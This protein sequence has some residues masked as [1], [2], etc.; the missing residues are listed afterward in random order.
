[1]YFCLSDA[2]KCKKLTSLI[3]SLYY[4]E[5]AVFFRQNIGKIVYIEKYLLKNKTS[6]AHFNALGM[7]TICMLP[8]T[9][10]VKNK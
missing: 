10:V 5:L 6:E 9:H 1:M 7:R 2:S 8:D 4:V 3:L